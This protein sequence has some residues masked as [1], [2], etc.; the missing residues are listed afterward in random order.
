MQTIQERHAAKVS[1]LGTPSY[2]YMYH[3]DYKLTDSMECV[4]RLVFRL[5]EWF[6]CHITKVAIAAQTFKYTASMPSHSN[7]RV[8]NNAHEMTP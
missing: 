7:I 1:M 3:I 6:A 4:L 8:E 2:S 5:P